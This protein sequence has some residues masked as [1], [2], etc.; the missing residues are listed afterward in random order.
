MPGP[1]VAFFSSCLAL[2][3]AAAVAHAQTNSLQVRPA[4]RELITQ[5][6]RQVVTVAFT[7]RNQT[8]RRIEAEPRL[9]LPA[10]WRIVTPELP[11]HIA[12]GETVVRLVSF[13]IPETARAGEYPVSYAVQDRQLPATRDAYAVRVN[14]LPEQKLQVLALESS[15][16][17][18]AGER[19]RAAFLVRNTGNAPIDA[20]FRIRSI[21]GSEP[22]PAAGELTLDAGESKTLEFTVTTEAVRRRVDEHL[23]LSV[24][25]PGTDIRSSAGAMTQVVPRIGT[26]QAYHTLASEVGLSLVVRDADGRRTNGWQAGLSG[27]G[28]LD[29]EKTRHLGVRLRGPN[30]QDRGSFGYTDDYALSYWDATT[31]ANVGDD[32]YGL[33]LLTDPG[34]VGRG[35]RAGYENDG[36][37]LSAY[38][39]K[40]RFTAD[41]EQA[42]FNVHS[43]LTPA[44]RLDLNLLDKRGGSLP[45]TLRSFGSRSQWRPGL[46]TAF[47]IGQSEG[48]GE[49]GRAWRGELYDSGHALRYHIFGWRAEPGYRGYV[50]DEE[51]LSTS[52][53]YP[54]RRWGLHGYYRFQKHNLDSDPSRAMPEERQASFGFDRALFKTA[55]ASLDY[56][57]RSYA[58]SFV[59]QPV[60]I[61]NRSTRLGLSQ[62]FKDVSLLYSVERGRTESHIGAVPFN[63][64]LHVLSA[65][66][67]ASAVQNYGLYATRDDNAYSKEPQGKQ[68]TLGLQASYD[69]ESTLLSFDA[70][71]NYEVIDDRDLRYDYTDSHY[72]RKTR[73]RTTYNMMLRHELRNGDRISLLARRIAGRQPQT[74]VLLT[75]TLPFEMPLFRKSNV[76]T[77]RG[78]IY[79]EE[80]GAGVRNVVLNLDGLTAVTDS[81]GR[82][83]FPAFPAGSHKLSMDRSNVGVNKVPTATFP[84]PIVTAARDTKQVDI[85]LVRSVSIGVKVSLHVDGANGIKGAVP[86]APAATRG[87][88]NVLVTLKNGDH[89]F[90]R[91]TDADGQV[92][93]GGLPPGDWT[94]SIDAAAIPEGYG[95]A[96]RE[97]A[98]PVP[99]GASATAEF[100]MVPVMRDIKM[101][102]PLQVD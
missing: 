4:D 79:D 92:R 87:A 50:R 84:L 91:L 20:A 96:S 89:V 13:M 10:G 12:D 76:A 66:W 30:I 25:V 43:R 101:L 41:H 32:I 2:L 34:H 99:P 33:S 40:D 59:G 49:R 36:L 71:R 93:I 46:N 64:T 63:T 95:I 45:A 18:I 5:Q 83:E 44:T 98:I 70:Q 7:V 88:A 6:P 23:T 47:E 21:Y 1:T 77:L 81:G 16:F 69:F 82:F 58:D 48:D 80:S 11:F 27:T 65:F 60:D 42:G 75:Y 15:T 3:L 54:Y 85:A 97:L 74:D 73:R 67:R 52:F 31:R 100:P 53:D 26:G 24:D 37:G 94:A 72:D 90:H 9:M 19:Y 56:Y 57:V 38:Q 17:A 78:R 61:E 51:Y 55:R 39:A 68:T 29:E 8:G 86:S 102:P 14:V 35:V 22:E 28:T 62:S